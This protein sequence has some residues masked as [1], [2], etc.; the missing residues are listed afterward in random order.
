MV[1][2]R[3]SRVC[4]PRHRTP[5]DPP[6]VLRITAPPAA[7]TASPAVLLTIS[8]L[9]SFGTGVV[10]NGLAFITR[11][12]YGYGEVENLLLAV[13]NGAFYVG[14]A[15]AAG[16][17][18]RRLSRRLTARSIVVL[19][20]VVQA[21][22]CPVPLLVEASWAIWPVAAVI[23]AASALLWPL[24]E[25][26][27]TAGRHGASMRSTIGW[28]NLVWM[29]AVTLSMLLMGPFLATGHAE[30]ILAA[31][32]ALFVAAAAAALALPAS[33]PPHAE[34]SASLHTTAQYPRLLASC[35]V[36]LPTSYL[37]V[38]AI[39]PLM[40][41]LLDHVRAPLASQT[42]MTS[43]WMLAR[44]AVVA[45]LWRSGFWHG[46]WS[47][48]LV[49]TV[50]LLGGFGA[51]VL[52]DSMLTMGLGLVAFGTGQGI[53]Y[54]ASLYYAMAVGRAEVDAGG[55]HEALIG[56]GYAVGPA[57]AF[58][59][60]LLAGGPGIVAAIWLAIG[61]ASLPAAAPW[62]RSRRR[63]AAPDPPSPLP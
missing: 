42:P 62:W 23:S 5:Y 58:G 35:R 24:V 28:W 4:P 25:S 12:S 3:P 9:A 57:L 43:L 15:F 16:P 8:F 2:Q 30:W 32:A 59:G 14:V 63:N 34:D 52:A 27:L 18:V 10:W 26:Y 7:S 47:T 54:Y 56:L 44:I 61:V 19:T 20:L 39:S 45:V 41:Y 48:L 37:V 36:L 31:L 51:M 22:A 13:F 21:A 6:P 11:E 29:A 50:L 38:G 49:A 17:I 53:V 46:R 40:P 55:T 1:A 33:P 60:S